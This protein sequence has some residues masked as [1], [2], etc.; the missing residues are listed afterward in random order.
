MILKYA[1]D[2]VFRQTIRNGQAFEEWFGPAGGLV[3]ILWKNVW[4]YRRQDKRKDTA[5]NQIS[6]NILTKWLNNLI[7]QFSR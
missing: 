7:F 3:I 4:V 6:K 2:T 5:V 1:I